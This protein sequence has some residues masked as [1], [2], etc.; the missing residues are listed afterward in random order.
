MGWLCSVRRGGETE[1]LTHLGS[2]R[3]HTLGFAL[4]ALSFCI[5]KSMSGT[6]LHNNKLPMTKG[7]IWK[8]AVDGFLS[9]ICHVF[10][11][12]FKAH[13]S[14][15]SPT[16]PIAFLFFLENKNNSKRTPVNTTTQPRHTPMVSKRRSVP[17]LFPPKEWTLNSWGTKNSAR[18]IMDPRG[19]RSNN[20]F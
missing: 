3:A 9:F 5:G 16:S 11:Y 17:S 7:I 18:N 20:L 10:P 19:H 4:V 2:Y 13:M 12:F 15:H 8:F 14:C 6:T 1:Q